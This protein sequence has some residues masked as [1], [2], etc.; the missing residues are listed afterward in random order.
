MRL[1]VSIALLAC[2]A[3][4]A[5]EPQYGFVYP[6][7]SEYF[8][9]AAAYPGASIGEA[10]GKQEARFF[11][12]ITLTLSTSTTTTTATTTVT[13]TSAAAGLAPC[14]PSGRKRRSQLGR[15]EPLYNEAEYDESFLVPLRK[16]R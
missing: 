11:Q 8:F 6:A 13:C 1:F 7:P 5:S 2:L 12:T 9:R 14:S 15:R 3:L 4:V 16:E 10:T